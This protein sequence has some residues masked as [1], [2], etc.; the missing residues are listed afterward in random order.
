MFEIAYKLQVFTSRRKRIEK[1]MSIQCSPTGCCSQSG[2]TVLSVIVYAHMCCVIE[3]LSLLAETL[4]FC[5][6][7]N[8]ISFHIESAQLRHICVLITHM[9]QNRAGFI[10]VPQWKHRL[11]CQSGVLPPRLRR[12][13]AHLISKRSSGCIY[14]RVNSKAPS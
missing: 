12:L 7:P 10:T 1:C 2:L 5:K 9:F 13:D 6:K 14:I 8:N 11:R 4:T 3:C